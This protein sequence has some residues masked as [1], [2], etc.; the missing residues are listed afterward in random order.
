MCTGLQD[1]YDIFRDMHL[2]MLTQHSLLISFL[3]IARMHL[4]SWEKEIHL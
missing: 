3:L 4:K 2:E 1:V